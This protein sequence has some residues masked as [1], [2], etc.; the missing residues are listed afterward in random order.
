MAELTPKEAKTLLACLIKLAKY[1]GEDIVGALL[2]NDKGAVG[3]VG[4]VDIRDKLMRGAASVLT[5][6]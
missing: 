6:R 4:A 5:E 2:K 3:E 1:E